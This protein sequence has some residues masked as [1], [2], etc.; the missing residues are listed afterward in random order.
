MSCG[1]CSISFRRNWDALIE[2]W[3]SGPDKLGLKLGMYE[4]GKGKRYGY[5][6]AVFGLLILLP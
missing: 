4:E 3:A 1:S 5:F 6:V 2:L